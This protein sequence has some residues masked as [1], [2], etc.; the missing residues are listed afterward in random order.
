MNGIAIAPAPERRAIELPIT[1]VIPQ[2]PPFLMVDAIIEGTPGESAVSR[3][4]VAP[5]NPI[6]QG[7]FPDDPVFPGVLLLENMAQ[8]ACWVM[9]AQA[10][11]APD[12]YVLARITQS[13]FYAMVR[14]GDVLMTRA[15]LSR[16]LDAF[17]QFDCEVFVAEQRVARA[18]L[19]VSRRER[20]TSAAE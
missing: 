11:G 17:S 3:Y 15:V 12:L 4:H 8:T 13:T 10:L 7:H 9:A 6:F 16:K 2:R 1:A 5:E 18:E 14:P 20:K 19:L